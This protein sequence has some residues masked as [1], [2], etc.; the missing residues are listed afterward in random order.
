MPEF[1]LTT[2]PTPAVIDRVCELAHAAL[3]AYAPHPHEAA[4]R[5]AKDHPHVQIVRVGRY[6]A[7]V[8]WD[9]EETVVAFRGNDEERQ[10][11]EA[12]SYGQVAWYGGRAHRGLSNALNGLWQGLLA[13]LFDA[14]ALDKPLY[15]TGHSLGGC[16]AVL[17]AQRLHSEGWSPSGV[18]T[19]GAPPVLDPVAADAYPAPCVRVVNNEDAIP[20]VC[21]PAILDSYRHVGRE[22]FLLASGRIGEARHGHGLARRIDRAWS[23]GDG[24]LLSGP[25]HD[26][27]MEHYV[28]KLDRLAA[29]SATTA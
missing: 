8:G 11:V 16:L 7:F 25:L 15:L 10:W 22:W 27:R 19:F 12:M 17:A 13:A 18:V 4:E 3:A 1:R 14:Q 26:H 20:G 5:I 9:N 6:S 23:I 2:E 29:S 24:P 28:E 21:W